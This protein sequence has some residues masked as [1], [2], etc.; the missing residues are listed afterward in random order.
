MATPF[1]TKFQ[2]AQSHCLDFSCILSEPL[3]GLC[4]ALSDAIGCPFEFIFFPLLTIVAACMGINAQVKVNPI[5]SE[6]AI[7]WFI[8]AATKG[9]KKTAALRIHFLKLN[10]MQL[11]HGR[12]RKEMQQLTQIL[13]PNLSLT[14]SVLKNYTML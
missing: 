6:P 9:Q 12:K 13:H 3:V 1:K 2:R 7:L 10:R 4:T 14:T 5:W 11:E 8:I